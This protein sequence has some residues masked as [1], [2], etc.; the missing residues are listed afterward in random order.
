[1]QQQRAVLKEIVPRTESERETRT[2]AQNW[3]ERKKTKKKT[4]NPAAPTTRNGG[5]DRKKER[6]AVKGAKRPGISQPFAG[7]GEAQTRT[8]AVVRCVS[9]RGGHIPDEE[10][11]QPG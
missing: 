6:P 7:L 8:R 1:M 10:T 5:G 2:T 11:W 3:A 9:G 4:C